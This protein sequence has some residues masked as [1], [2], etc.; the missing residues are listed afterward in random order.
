M[1]DAGSKVYLLDGVP[2]LSDAPP[3]AWHEWDTAKNEWTIS[4]D[5]QKAKYQAETA[6]LEH[7]KDRRIQAAND[8]INNKQW[9]SKLSLGRLSNEERAQFNAWLDYLDALEAID[10]STA[11]DISWPTAPAK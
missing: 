5:G 4:K 7:D 2:T 10:T 3:D 9:P 6:A 8:H 11:P 1:N